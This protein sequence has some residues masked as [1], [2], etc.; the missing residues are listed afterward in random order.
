MAGMHVLVIDDEEGIRAGLKLALEDRFN[1]QLACNGPEGIEK[2][3]KNRPDVVLLDMFMEGGNGNLVLQY[4]ADNKIDIPV[5]IIS[6]FS[7]EVLEKKFTQ[8]LTHW[9]HYRKPI[10]VMELRKLLDSFGKN[11][12]ETSERR[13]G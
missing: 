8:N 12:G 4:L 13:P 9:V 5:V 11:N 6:A 3:H 1:V 10:D 2:I 7:T